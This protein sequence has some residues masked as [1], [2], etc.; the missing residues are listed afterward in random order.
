M[1]ALERHLMRDYL[2]RD[3][4]KK[5]QLLERKC[6]NSAAL[7]MA[8]SEPCRRSRLNA[9]KDGS[10]DILIANTL[11]HWSGRL[12]AWWQNYDILMTPSP[13]PGRIGQNWLC[14]VAPAFARCCSLRTVSVV[15]C[16]TSNAPAADHSK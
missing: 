7:N 5:W 6:A 1:A 2:H 15:C 13:I 9:L 4:G 10:P 3:L 8:I 14:V 16:A 12:S 11:R